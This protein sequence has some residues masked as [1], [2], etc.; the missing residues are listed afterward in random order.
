M[1]WGLFG[2]ASLFPV[3]SYFPGRG[4]RQIS[5][6]IH[7]SGPL[8]NDV[9]SF[10]GAVYGVGMKGPEY[11]VFSVHIPSCHYVYLDMVVLV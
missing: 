5:S 3:Y 4:C 11:P 10:L 9:D 7:D 8:S 2:L 6:G 1:P